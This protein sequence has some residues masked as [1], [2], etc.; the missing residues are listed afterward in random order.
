MKL[1]QSLKNAFLEFRTTAFI[2]NFIVKF[3]F[4]LLFVS[5]SETLGIIHYAVNTNRLNKWFRDLL[6][7][8]CCNTMNVI[9]MLWWNEHHKCSHNLDLLYNNIIVNVIR[10]NGRKNN[11]KDMNII[12]RMFLIAMYTLFHIW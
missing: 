12:Y 10:Q 11:C 7:S 8:L 9:Y 3:D 5:V 2:K 4:W 1:I 6:F